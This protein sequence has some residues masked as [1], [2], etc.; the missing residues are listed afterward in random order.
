MIEGLSDEENELVLRALR[1]YSES[2]EAPELIPECPF[3]VDIG[4]SERGCGEEC[5][6]LL[7]QHEAPRPQRQ[8]Q[9]ATGVVV[10]KPTRPRP[11]RF[12]DQITRPFDAK[13]AYLQ[14]SEGGGIETW[15]LPAILYSAK[16][17]LESPPPAGQDLEA[18]QT[19]ILS[20]VG[21]LVAKGID[22]DSLV[23][24]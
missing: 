8:I 1:T 2:C 13:E 10:H 3:S 24:P 23:E 11:R 12:R 22:F 7:G 19:D 6:D 21:S 5:M 17:I 16:D 20:L 9:L 14:D 18:R 15:R 4:P